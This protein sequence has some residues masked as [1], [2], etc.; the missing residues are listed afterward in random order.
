MKTKKYFFN[1]FIIFGLSLSLLTACDI[2]KE[3]PEEVVQK[4]KQAMV[5][6]KSGNLST[7][8]NIKGSDEK[9][10]INLMANLGIKFD[11]N[12]K[13]EPKADISVGIKGDMSAADKTMNG[14]LD[15]K[16]R[17]IGDNFY[18]SL[19]KLDATDKEI[20]KIKP[21]IS[22]YIGKWLHIANDFIPEEIRDQLKG[23]DA[24]M[25]A[26]E[27]ELKTLFINTNFFTIKKEYGVENVNGKK[28]YHYGI[29]LDENSLKEYIKQAAK[30]QGEEI[31]EADLD[32]VAKLAQS[33]TDIELW[34]GAKDYYLYKATANW[35]GGAVDS[36]VDIQVKIILEGKGYNSAIDI[37]A[38]SDAQE[39][40]PLML[41]MGGMM[42]PGLDMGEVTDGKMPPVPPSSD[43][44]DQLMEKI[45][46]ES[47][48]EVESPEEAEEAAEVTEEETKE[49]EKVGNETNSEE[50]K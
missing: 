12:D 5:E 23:K 33:A 20:E 10:K 47:G 17:I 44:M 15:F 36:G 19:N 49:A 37:T 34:I 42:A 21:L 3:T 30:I 45:E 27:E 32:E 43:D 6:V 9:D 40:N 18:I 8:M 38:P 39:F 24:E 29:S 48:E 1:L 4:F 13:E 11:Q 50:S 41:L 25:L 7:S 26:K 35:D 2:P 22:P 16:I 46:V 14:D 31:M 28:T